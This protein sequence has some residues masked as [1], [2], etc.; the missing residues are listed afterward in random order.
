LKLSSDYKIDKRVIPSLAI[1]YV[2]SYIDRASLGNA[3]IFGY[4]ASLGINVTQYNLIV[5]VVSW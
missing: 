4:R 5:T 2:I 1:L 3:S